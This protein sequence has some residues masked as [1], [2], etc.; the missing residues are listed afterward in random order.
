MRRTVGDVLEIEIDGLYAYAQVTTDPFVV[1][2][3]SLTAGRKDTDEAVELP[4]A[5][6]ICVHN[7]DI[8]SGRWKRIGK[9][10]LTQVRLDKPYTFR[11]DQLTGRLY[12]HHDSFASTGWERPATLSECRGLEAAAVWDAQHVEDR[13]RDHF[14]GDE[15]PWQKALEIDFSRVPDDQRY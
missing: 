5:F 11:Q 3:D 14:R 9:G 12:L 1:F 6:T 13:L 7:A 4:V 2:F 8:R 15:N 10:R